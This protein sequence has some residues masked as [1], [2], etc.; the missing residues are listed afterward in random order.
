MREGATI[1]SKDQDFAMLAKTR[2]NGPSVVWIRVGN[3]SASH[4]DAILRSHLAEIVAALEAGERLLEI[5]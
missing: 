3:T 1:V 4:L 5:V 2:V